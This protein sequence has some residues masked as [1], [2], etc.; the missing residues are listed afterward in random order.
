MSQIIP[1]PPFLECSPLPAPSL[2]ARNCHV[3]HPTGL[4]GSNIYL[5]LSTSHFRSCGCEDGVDLKVTISKA[6]SKADACSL[7]CIRN[8]NLMASRLSGVLFYTW[9]C[10]S[11]A[12]MQISSAISPPGGA[13]R[14]VE[15][16]ECSEYVMQS[17]MTMKATVV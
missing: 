9:D 7:R 3:G 16:V 11:T 12:A 2:T 1:P 17:I 8:F 10:L 13:V 15:S 4:C 5:H 6:A 14:I